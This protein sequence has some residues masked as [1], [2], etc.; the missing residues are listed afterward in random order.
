M[1][2][3]KSNDEIIDDAMDR[4]TVL[5][6]LSNYG[7]YYEPSK[8]FKMIMAKNMAELEAHNHKSFDE[9]IDSAIY[10]AITEMYG[11][12]SEEEMVVPFNIIK[13]QVRK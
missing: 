4:M 13:S 1:S 5:G 6:I 8:K 12:I 10:L 11:I 3:K 7:K 9:N 2:Q